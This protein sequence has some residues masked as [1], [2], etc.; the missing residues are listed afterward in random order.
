MAKFYYFPGWAE[1]SAQAELMVNKKAWE[2]LPKD[3]Q[4]IVFAAA[5]EVNTWGFAQFE[6]QN[7]AALAEIKKQ[8]A[9]VQ[10]KG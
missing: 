10:V 4:G 2:S 8:F 5:M 3:L 6:V 7:A 1:P 9:D